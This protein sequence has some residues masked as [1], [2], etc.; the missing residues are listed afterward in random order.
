MYIRA[1]GNIS[2]QKTFGHPPFLTEPVEYPGSRL[3]C[4]EPEYKEIID[5]KLIRRMSRIIRMGVAAA[6]ECLQEAGVKQPDAIITGTAYGC[7][8][9][10]GLFLTKM[11]EYNEELLTPT[12]FIQ[13][14]H[15]TIGAQIGLMLQCN[16]YNN[17]FVH[18]GFSFENALL[19]GMMLLK[20]KEAGNVL[21]GAI[22]EITDISH[23]ILNRMG[24]YK[25]ELVLNTELFKSA[26]IAIGAKGTIAGE[27]ASFFLLANEPSATDYAKLLGLK[28]FYK[29]RGLKEIEEHIVSF[30]GA[31]SVTLNDIDLVITGRN[32]D[33]GLD[34]IFD[35]LQQSI[36]SKKNLINY[37][38]LCGEY[39]TSTAFALWVAANI[40]KTTEVPAVFEYKGPGEKKIGRILIY[41]H[42]QDIHHSLILIAAC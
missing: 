39:P 6:M 15:N 22:D 4:A 33:N 20:E 2:P 7:L 30:L 28:T 9:D 25:Q 31:H 34:E 41:N 14:T 36:F 8:E 26:P 12:A 5:V 18:R 17:T 35:Q 16:N 42:Y 21:L 19:D 23:T 38:H 32:G 24:L 29:P 27:G 1:T 3:A 37:K 40:I 11:V 10:T 13:S